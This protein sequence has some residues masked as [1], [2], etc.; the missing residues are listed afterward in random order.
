MHHSVIESIKYCTA[1]Y[2]EV[3][4]GQNGM[5]VYRPRI[6]RIVKK[7]K[8]VLQGKKLSKLMIVSS[9]AAFL[10]LMSI[11]AVSKAITE[12]SHELFRY[13]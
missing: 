9:I 3:K 1:H 6:D 10:M 2:G 13:K 4:A 11:T 5:E 7:S 12:R 8:S